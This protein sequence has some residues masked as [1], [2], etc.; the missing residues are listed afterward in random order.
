MFLLGTTTE[1][2]VVLIF[3]NIFQVEP[4]AIVFY[5]VH[6]TFE[7]SPCAS[8]S[9]SVVLTAPRCFSSQ[10]THM[11]SEDLMKYSASRVLRTGSKST[12]L[13]YQ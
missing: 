10:G 9:C 5:S 6:H 4:S 7:A 11:P 12:S 13:T 2:E 3:G 8:S 1:A